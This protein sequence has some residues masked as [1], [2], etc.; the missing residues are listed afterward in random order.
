ME[1]KYSQETVAAWQNTRTWREIIFKA[2][3]SS[4][5]P[6]HPLKKMKKGFDTF[7]IEF[8]GFPTEFPNTPLLKDNSHSPE[9][10]EICKS[11]TEMGTLDGQ[12]FS[13]TASN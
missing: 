7:P 11:D 6:N 10:L 4:L 9:C 13:H 8:N 3:Y 2:F 5:H 12:K 1:N